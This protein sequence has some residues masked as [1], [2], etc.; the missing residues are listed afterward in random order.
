MQPDMVRWTERLFF[1]PEDSFSSDCVGDVKKSVADS[2]QGQQIL[3]GSS[4]RLGC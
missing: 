3:D 2:Q 4:G 1:R